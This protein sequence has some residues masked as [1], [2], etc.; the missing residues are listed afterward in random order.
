MDLYNKY[1]P[2][3]F[4]DMCDTSG[5]LKNI[6]RRV[7]AVLDGDDKLA[8]A[9]L[10]YSD[11][12][13]GLGK[14]TCAR[15]LASALNPSLPDDERDALFRGR[16]CI[17]CEEFDATGAKKPDVD[18]LT[19]RIRCLEESLYNYRYIFIINEA[20][21]LTDDSMQLMLA[22]VENIPDRVYLVFTTTE[23][24][25]LR[26][27][28]VSR[29][30]AHF[31]Y[32]PSYKEVD[33]LLQTIAKGEGFQGLDRSVSKNIFELSSG[34]LRQCIMLL[35]QYVANGTLDVPISEDTEGT[36]HILALLR[37]YER[38]GNEATYW[39]T[40]AT[41]L[42]TLLRT[43]DVDGVRVDLL[44][45]VGQTLIRQKE[46]IDY[47]LARKYDILIK[48]LLEPVGYPPNTNLL[49]RMFRAYIE[50]MKKPPVE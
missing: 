39:S 22:A 24:S 12:V 20:Q 31:F 43:S 17:V 35:A 41:Q 48:H 47:L 50:I 13:P 46:N 4:A 32:A 37:L 28:L 16:P 23:R 15:I 29:L 30:E 33:R 38:A 1:R 25:R 18:D 44:R 10:F 5:F 8:H 21:K 27:D 45:R 26:K 49:L 3:T 14:T 42:D 36:P 40:I 11:G 2:R 6:D 7:K 19:G 9:L 34:D